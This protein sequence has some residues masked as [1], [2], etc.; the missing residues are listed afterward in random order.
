MPR[1]PPFREV[2]R[3]PRGRVAGILFAAWLALP[4]G[5]QAAEANSPVSSASHEVVEITGWIEGS[6]NNR[7]LPFAVV[8]KVNARVFVFGGD[9]RLRGAAPVLLGLTKGDDNADGIGTRKLADISPD[10]RITPA[11]RF[12]AA[13]GYDLKQD[14]LWVDYAAALSL[15]RVIVGNPRDRRA[16][17]LASPSSDDN[18]ITYGCINVPA[19]FYDNVIVPTFTATIGIV[20]I[21]PETRPVGTAFAM[22]NHTAGSARK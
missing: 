9:G 13:L 6:G 20:Y 17:R 14:I 12:E 22:H 19:A 3:T 15:H 8:D 2:R 10:E 16:E 4:T 1:N 5:L 7:H 21:L 18:R 11:G